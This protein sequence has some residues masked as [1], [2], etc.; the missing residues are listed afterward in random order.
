MGATALQQGQGQQDRQHAL[1]GA[2]L[3]QH[4]ELL[5]GQPVEPSDRGLVAP[6][7][8]QGSRQF[9][10]GARRAVV[11]VDVRLVVPTG[12]NGHRA[13]RQVDP[14]PGVGFLDRDPNRVVPGLVDLAVLD[15]L[16]V[17]PLRDDHRDRAGR[18]DQG[19]L[20][21]RRLGQPEGHGDR[22]ARDAV[23]VVSYLAG[24][25]R[26]PQ[27]HRRPDPVEAAEPFEQQARHRLHEVPLRHVA[28]S[29][30]EHAVPTVLAIAP[31]PRKP[32]SAEGFLQHRVQAVPHHHLVR[33]PTPFPEPLDIHHDDG[34]VQDRL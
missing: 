13:V 20:Q 12:E 5:A 14:R 32:R 6:L 30:D 25:H 4:H 21:R 31:V 28:G 3:A 24:V 16:V 9:T 15:H 22:R 2:G 8:V 23:I 11:P 7:A 33:D 27:P 1:A 17:E 34:A 29:Q 19:R 10:E 18:G 26:H